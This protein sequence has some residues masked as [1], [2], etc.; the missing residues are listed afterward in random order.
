MIRKDTDLAAWWIREFLNQAAQERFW[1]PK[2]AD[3]LV[4]E[5]RTTIAALASALPDVQKALDT[6]ISWIH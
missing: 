6:W 3:V 2:T 5:L 1:E 4:L